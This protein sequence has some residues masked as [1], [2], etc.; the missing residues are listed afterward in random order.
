MAADSILIRATR[1]WIARRTGTLGNA[2]VDKNG[3]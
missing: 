2:Q 3:N 1:F